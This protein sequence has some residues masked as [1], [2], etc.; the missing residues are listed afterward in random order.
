MFSWGVSI[1]A[2]DSLKRLVSNM[3]DCVPSGTLNFSQSD[4]CV[5]VCGLSSGPVYNE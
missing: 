4:R 5:Y 3:P 1:S 2:I